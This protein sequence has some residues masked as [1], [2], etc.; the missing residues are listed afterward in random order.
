[1]FLVL[2]KVDD[3]FRGFSEPPAPLLPPFG[4]EATALQA[5]APVHGHESMEISFNAGALRVAVSPSRLRQLDAIAAQMKDSSEDS[6]QV[7]PDESL[8][9]SDPSDLIDQDDTASMSGSDIF[10]NAGSVDVANAG[11]ANGRVVAARVSVLKVS[12][13]LIG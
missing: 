7:D 6:S 9:A 13:L 5:L 12:F 8:N 3:S 4:A 10:S 2:L 1:M 11:S